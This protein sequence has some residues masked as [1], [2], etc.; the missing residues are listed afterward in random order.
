MP[1]M[2]GKVAKN[3][4]AVRALIACTYTDKLKHSWT[5]FKVFEGFLLQEWLFQS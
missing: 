3:V 5:Q 4:K 2:V 1:E